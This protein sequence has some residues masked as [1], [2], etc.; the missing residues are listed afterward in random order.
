MRKTTMI[1]SLIAATFL[2]VG[3]TQAAPK[4]QANQRRTRSGAEQRTQDCAGARKAR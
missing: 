3:S 1:S 4:R 2:L